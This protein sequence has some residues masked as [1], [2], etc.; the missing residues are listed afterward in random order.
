MSSE[1]RSI[2]AD[3]QDTSHLLYLGRWFL[4]ERR[5]NMFLVYK[6]MCYY[7]NKNPY[8]EIRVPKY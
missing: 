6:K 1:R 7:V 5:G 4:L 2:K 3:S 8:F